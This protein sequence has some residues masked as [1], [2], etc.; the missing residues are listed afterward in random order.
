N[1]E[2]DCAWIKI[3]ERLEAIGQ[4]D[5]LVE[6]RPP[7]DYSKQNNPRSFVHRKARI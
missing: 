5:N 1:T 7:K 3:Y 6:I 2:N 4:L